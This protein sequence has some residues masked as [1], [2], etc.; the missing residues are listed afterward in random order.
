MAIS[1]VTFRRRGRNLC[2][3]RF[4]A[5]YINAYLK[6]LYL[7]NYTLNFGFF[8]PLSLQPDSHLFWHYSFSTVVPPYIAP[9]T[10]AGFCCAQYHYKSAVWLRIT[11]GEQLSVG[12][13]KQYKN[14]KFSVQ[15]NGY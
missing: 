7:F 1:G 8:S 9:S 5:A 13:L 14:P 10:H 4:L 12:K 3:K 11:G 6:D 2:R 15:L